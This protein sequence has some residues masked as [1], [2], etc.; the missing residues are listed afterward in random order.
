MTK[1]LQLLRPRQWTKG[2]FILFPIFLSG[3]Y[4]KF[5]LNKTLEV[6]VVLFYF[7]LVTITI[8]IINDI[9]DINQDKEHKQKRSRPIAS[10]KVSL[11]NAIV[12]LTLIL[13]TTLMVSTQIKIEI[14]YLSALYFIIN[15]LYNLGIKSIA[16]WEIFSVSSGF[17]IRSLIGSNLIIEKPTIYFYSSVFAVSMII[18]VL[19]RRQEYKEKRKNKKHVR[20]SLNHYTETGLTILLISMISLLFTSYIQI[21]LEKSISENFNLSSFFLLMSALPMVAMTIELCKN[22]KNFLYETP[23]YL[24]TSNNIVK[25]NLMIWTTFIL[26]SSIMEL[27][28][29]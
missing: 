22:E 9:I 21:V 1:Y 19:K 28:F 29:A 2:I 10:G 7:T 3:E 6:V 12:L 17:V 8:Y 13:I 20:Q 4:T 16:Y 11:I 25:V 5:N 26:F 23:E 24:L 15:M 27:V 18:V 14:V